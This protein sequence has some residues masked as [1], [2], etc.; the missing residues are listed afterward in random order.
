MFVTKDVVF[1]P[2]NLPLKPIVKDLCQSTSMLIL[3]LPVSLQQEHEETSRVMK[4]AVRLA[5]K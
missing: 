3:F 4:K 1:S 5:Y 2:I